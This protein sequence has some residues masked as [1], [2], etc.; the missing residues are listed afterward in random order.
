MSSSEAA[1]PDPPQSAQPESALA[2][3]AGIAERVAVL[4][5]LVE[6]P[7]ADHIEIFHRLHTELQAT[8]AEIAGP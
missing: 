1:M 8:L 3:P 7:L 5:S 4:D 2:T 6:L